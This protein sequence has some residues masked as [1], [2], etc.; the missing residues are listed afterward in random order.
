MDELTLS[1]G[2]FTV[3]VYV[4]E[5]G[6]AD[7]FTNK[8]IQIPSIRS[9]NQ[10]A[11]PKDGKTLDLL[12]ITHQLVIKAN[13]TGTASKT[14]IETKRDLV[15]IWKGAGINKG[16]VTLTYGGNAKAFGNTTDTS[17]STITGYIEKLVFVDGAMDEPSDFES[18]KENYQDIT[19][20]EVAIT[21]VEGVKI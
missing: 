13:M 20:F 19:K 11:G 7:N 17:S 15:N 16:E 18:S 21:F 2:A 4:P 9:S 1:K 3:T 10:E 6:I 14:A 5:K 12:R 8:L